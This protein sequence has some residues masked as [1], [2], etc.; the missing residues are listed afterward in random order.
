MN[1]ELRRQIAQDA[2]PHRIVLVLTVLAVIFTLATLGGGDSAENLHDVGLMIA[3]L[4]IA[5]WGTRRVAAALAD[6]VTG[7]TWDIQ[8]MSTLGAGAMSFAKLAGGGAFAGGVA[9]IGLAVAAFAGASLSGVP[10]AVMQTLSLALGGVAVLAAS[11]AVCLLQVRRG[12]PPQVTGCQVLAVLGYAVVAGQI[13]ALPPMWFGLGVAAQPLSLALLAG[14]M[15]LAVYRLMRFELM[16]SSIPWALPAFGIGLTVYLVGFGAGGMATAFPVFAVL[17]YGALF[18]ERKDITDARAL[19]AAGRAGD[20]RGV[21]ERLPMWLP[22]LALALPS[23]LIA[24]SAPLPFLTIGAVSTVAMAGFLAR[25][26]L[27]VLFVHLS[28]SKRAD[29]TALVYLVVLH[30]LLPTLLKTTEATAGAASLFWPTGGGLSEASASV[31]VLLAVGLIVARR[32][33]L[34]RPGHGGA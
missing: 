28:R 14:A 16:Y 3:K 30:A 17:T 26:V 25:D 19:L 9:A 13:A 18:S 33:L 15:V 7:H 1:P 27:I 5:L 4:A 20:W 12:G 24:G 31:Q 8:R 22:V 23:G 21:G 6:E 34:T 29:Q 32:L 10:G 2:T 11:L